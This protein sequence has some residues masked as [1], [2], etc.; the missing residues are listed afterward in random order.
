MN[1]SIST[2][3][4]LPT[5]RPCIQGAAERDV[6]YRMHQRGVVGYRSNINNNQISNALWVRQGYFHRHFPTHGVANERNLA[7]TEV[8]VDEMNNCT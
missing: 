8:P 2:T 7:D 3:T 5:S 4:K 1:S 6:L